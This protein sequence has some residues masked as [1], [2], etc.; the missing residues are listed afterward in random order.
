[1]AIGFEAKGAFAIVM[2]VQT[3]AIWA[4][5]DSRSFDLNNPAGP[6]PGIHPDDWNPSEDPDDIDYLTSNVWV[7]QAT[8]FPYEP[9]STFKPFT[10]CM[11]LDEQKVGLD[12][13][14]S[15]APVWVGDWTEYPISCWAEDYGFNHGAVTLGEAIMHSCNPPFVHLALRLGIDKFYDYI[16][17]MGMNERTGIDL[18]AESVG[19]VHQDPNVV[20][21]ATLAIGEQSTITGIRLA[22]LYAALGNGGNMMT[23]HIA[24]TL[25]DND[26]NVV[27]QFKPEI[28]RRVFSAESTRL[29]LERMIAGTHIGGSGPDIYFPGHLSAGKTGTSLAPYGDQ[30]NACTYTV[31]TVTPYNDPQFVV[32]VSLQVPRDD[33]SSLV[34]QKANR[35]ITRKVME[36][37]K[38]EPQWIEYDWVHAWRQEMLPA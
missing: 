33:Q 17:L 25:L 32:L 21:M 35:Y 15:D 18:P 4:M 30:E 37:M 27:R 26:G 16:N 29:V 20:D 22:Q 23:P 14:L 10:S 2:D 13:Y 3:G 34:L 9:G 12:E 31:A 28:Q 38:F 36:E 11:A 8:M 7:N 6:P 1:M 19:L 24:D 5:A